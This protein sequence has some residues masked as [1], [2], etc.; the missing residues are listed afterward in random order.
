[1]NRF[2]TSYSKDKIW[3][4][5]LGH[6]NSIVFFPKAYKN[7]SPWER[8]V[9][10]VHFW[11]GMCQVREIFNHELLITAEEKRSNSNEIFLCIYKIIENEKNS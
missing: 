1:M 2:L 5:A 7:Q 11:A 8:K 10:E 6:I 9:I 4:Q 3:R